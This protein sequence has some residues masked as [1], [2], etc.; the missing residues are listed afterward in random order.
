LQENHRQQAEIKARMD[1]INVTSLI[2][3]SDLNGNFIYV[4]DKF[5]EISKYTRD[6]LIGKSQ[7]IIAHPELPKNITQE[8]AETLAQGKI[9]KNTIPCKAKDGSTFYVETIIGPVLGD[10]AKP[11]KFLNVLNDITESYKQSIEVKTQANKIDKIITTLPDSLITSNNNGNILTANPAFLNLANCTIDTLPK[12]ITEVLPILKLDKIETNKKYRQKFATID[13]QT[14]MVNLVMQKLTEGDV[15]NLV[16]ILSDITDAIK[17]DQEL[18]V[19]LEN[20]QQ[21]KVKMQSQE[22]E[23]RQNMEEMASTQE[24]MMKIQDALTIKNNEVNDEKSKMTQIMVD[25]KNKVDEF[26]SE[27]EML[28]V[29]LKMKD[30]QIEDLKNNTK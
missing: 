21:E 30:K 16:F 11:I 6:E 26:A 18:I 14:K 27:I 2:T 15:D 25:H 29:Q 13:K 17:K 19:T 20:L 10:N 22:E 24:E 4:N 5:C 23:M 8:L 9:Y 28:S 7:N 1:L 12:N 3:E